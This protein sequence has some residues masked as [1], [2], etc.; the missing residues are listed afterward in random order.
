LIVPDASSLAGHSHAL[1]RCALCAP[2]GYGALPP[3]LYDFRRDSSIRAVQ[4]RNLRRDYFTVWKFQ[5]EALAEE[6]R[7][8]FCGEWLA[9]AE[10]KM[11]RRLYAICG[12]AMSP[13]SCRKSLTG[14]SLLTF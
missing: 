3:D 10:R 14:W 7:E 8:R 11:A 1:R 5:T 13:F 6:F 4:A 2:N 12:G 9:E